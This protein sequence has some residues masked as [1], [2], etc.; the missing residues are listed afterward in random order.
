MDIVKHAK[1]ELKVLSK[2]QGVRT[3]DVRKASSR[4]FKELE[5]KNKQ[6]VFAHCEAMLDTGEWALW[7][8]AYDWAYRVRKQYDET[9]FDVFEGWLKKYVKGW[10]DCDDFCT[11]AF[12][13]LLAKDNAL[14]ER[15]LPWVNDE[16]FA[17][18]RAAPVIL[19][20]PIN[21]DEYAGFDPFAISDMLMQD[22][23]HLVQK[24]YGWMLKVLSQKEPKKVI[25][26]LLKNKDVMPRTAY[27]YALEKLDKETKALLMK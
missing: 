20:Y 24:G 14:F 18:R 5:N 27:R 13:Y 6:N 22:G 16:N 19:I 10:S 4:L 3:G 17:V 7:L 2:L 15:I 9:T 23:H 12:G 25:D 8:M 1:E 21:H 11:H 26:Y